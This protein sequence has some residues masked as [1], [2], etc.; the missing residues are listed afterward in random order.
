MINSQ[1]IN[2]RINIQ[3]RICSQEDQTDPQ[4]LEN[5]SFN[6][7]QALQQN[8]PLH[9]YT[10]ISI[11]ITSKQLVH[12]PAKP[13]TIP[14]CA[15]TS[16]RTPIDETQP[17]TKSPDLGFPNARIRRRNTR[18]NPPQNTS[19]DAQSHQ[20]KPQNPNRRGL[21]SPPENRSNGVDEAGS[22]G[23]AEIRT[24]KRR[25][26]GGGRKGI[27]RRARVWEMG[28]AWEEVEGEGEKLGMEWK[29]GVKRELLREIYN[30]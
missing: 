8:P 26:R 21:H 20:A 5:L 15:K 13:W 10:Q 19:S 23:A 1:C 28:E 30:Y 12:S 16:S 14:S 7:H 29:R 9:K 22:R 3:A 27:D 4:T 17:L 6:S 25:G 2:R 11:P 18:T 24:G